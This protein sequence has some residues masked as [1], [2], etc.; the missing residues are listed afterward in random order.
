MK[1]FLYFVVVFFTVIICSCAGSS[2]IV[3]HSLSRNKNV[4]KKLCGKVLIYV[5]FVDTKAG[6]KWNDTAIR[7]TL[8]L[9]KD[10]ANWIEGQASKNDVKLT[11]QI[12]SP[13]PN[14]AVESDFPIKNVSAITIFE[15]KNFKKLNE[16]TDGI[17]KKIAVNMTDK[18]EN[19]SL[20]SVINPKDAE[21][22]IARLRNQ[23]NTESVALFFATN[24]TDANEISL[25]LNTTNNE[26]IERVINSYKN[27]SI[28]AY[29]LLSLFGAE[30]LFYSKYGHSKKYAEFAAKEFPEDLMIDPFRDLK[31][32]NISQFTQYLIGWRNEIDKQYFRLFK[33]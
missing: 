8:D 9:Y 28:I 17:V 1:Q 29:E 15:N 32:A 20:P 23:Y 11:I 7:S 33:Y 13:S 5:V 26:D 3:D 30:K 19:D 21:R 10:A 12:K 4:C 22:L 2:K 14:K 6:P 18:N 16:W 25:Q 31:G 27:S 24:H